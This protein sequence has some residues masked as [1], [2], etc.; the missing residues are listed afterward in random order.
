VFNQFFWLWFCFGLFFGLNH[1]FWVQFMVEPKISSSVGQVN[2][3]G[4]MT[5]ALFG[6]P[7]F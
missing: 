2:L 4:S 6:L 5:H 1:N 7:L 3:V